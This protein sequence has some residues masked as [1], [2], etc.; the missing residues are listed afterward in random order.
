MYSSCILWVMKDD[1]DRRILKRLQAQGNATNAELADAGGMSVSQAGRRRAR[2]EADGVIESYRARLSPTKLGL[3][4]QA[5][6]QISLNHHSRDSADLLHRYLA[7]QDEIVNIWSLT[8]SA[9]YLLQVFCR[10]L[11]ALNRLVHDD[12]LA[13]ASISH[14]ETKIVMEQIKSGTALPLDRT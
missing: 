9:D 8:G 14:V 6:I 5:M 3:E 4:I 1:F 11:P 13:Q 10:D 12:L 7:D 2:L